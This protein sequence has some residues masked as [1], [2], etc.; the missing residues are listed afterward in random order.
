MAGLCSRPQLG[1]LGGWGGW[2]GVGVHSLPCL[3]LALGGLSIG[4]CVTSG[5]LGLP[6]S[7]AASAGGIS[8]GSQS[9]CSREGGAGSMT[10]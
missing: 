2:I 1:R 5:S 10:V 9:E 4:V 6:H 7:M 8:V 3:V